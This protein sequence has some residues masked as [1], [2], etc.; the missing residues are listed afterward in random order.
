[1]RTETCLKLYIMKPK[2]KKKR[3]E[4]KGNRNKKSCY[5][6]VPRVVLRP[7][8]RAQQPPPRPAAPTWWPLVPGRSNPGLEVGAFSPGFA[9]PDA[10]PRLK[11]TTA[12]D[13]KPFFY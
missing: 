3:N 6:S 5:G 11:A 10:N 13:Y 8:A 4:K 9:V 1:M 12:Q 2:L 7:R